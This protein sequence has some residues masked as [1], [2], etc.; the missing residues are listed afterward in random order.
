MMMAALGR[1]QAQTAAS[2]ASARSASKYNNENIRDQLTSANNKAYGQVAF[3]PVAGVAPPA[4]VMQ[5]GPN[6]LSLIGGI[7]SSI[8]SGMSAASSLSAPNP[9]A[10][11]PTPAPTSGFAPAPVWTAPQNLFDN[12]NYLTYP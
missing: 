1:Q 10:P 12:T 11:T 7:G 2:L 8:A 4:P 3:K 6:A 5:D 9:T